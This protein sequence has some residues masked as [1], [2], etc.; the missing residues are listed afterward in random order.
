MALA[1]RPDYPFATA[2]LADIAMKRN[3]YAKAEQLLDEACAGIPE[4]GF[5]MQKAALYQEMDRTA[6]AQQVNQEIL[7]MLEDDEAHGHNMTLEY[8]AVYR[9]L[10]D[11]QEKAL[12]YAMKAYEARPNNIDVNQMLT[13][14]YL[15]M[16]KLEAASEHLEKAKATRARKASLLCMQGL[17][18]LRQ[19]QE[20]AGL[21]SLRASMS[22]NPHQSHGFVQEAKAYLKG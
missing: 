17:I 21:R 15:K 4:V 7:A 20:E 3:E 11:D 5:Y 16:N 22:Y 8:A 18:Q 13:S 14:I 12:E 2:A 9:D 6:E 19:G 1:E 10:M